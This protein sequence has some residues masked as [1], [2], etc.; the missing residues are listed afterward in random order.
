MKRLATK[1]PP[2]RVNLLAL[3]DEYSATTGFSVNKI[4]DEMAWD[5][6][7]DHV[8]YVEESDDDEEQP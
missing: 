6:F 3:V 2:K 8:E 1:P 7:Y 5:T 4:A